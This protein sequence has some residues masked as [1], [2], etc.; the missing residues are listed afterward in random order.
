MKAYKL[1]RVRKDGSIGS[2]FINA[3]ARLPAGVWL[4]AEEHRK[5]GFAF[6]PGWHVMRK[7]DAP[8]LKMELASGEQRQWWEVEIAWFTKEQRPDSQGGTWYLAKQMKLIR[9]VTA[10]AERLVA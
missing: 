5:S 4:Q 6:R 8:H 10:P 3:A 7:P 9:P 2:L 1:M